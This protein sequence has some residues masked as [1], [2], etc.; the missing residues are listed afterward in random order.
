VKQI[1]KRLTYAN[2]MSSIAV[3]LMLGGATAFAATKIGSNEIKGNAITTGKIKK[4]AVSRAK[5]KKNAI[6]A[7]KLADGSVTNSKLAAD[8]VTGDKVKDGSLTGADLNL[9]TVGTVPSANNA[10]AV[11]GQSIA[12]FFKEVPTN[13]AAV[14]ALEFGGVKLTASCPA[15]VP[16]LTAT[17]TSGIP[18]A[19]R[20]GTV[21]EAAEAFGNGQTSF[22]TITVTNAKALGAGTV[23]AVFN[24]GK[25]TSISLAYR[26]D[27]FNGSGC[28]FFGHAITG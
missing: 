4:E 23:E 21:L 15:T 14:T 26:S 11:N 27:A 5:I 17:N 22:S 28:R 16:N 19:I 25:V 9:G 8:A 3:F 6:D 13:G 7:S 12:S 1:R 20:F 24:N 2:V 18:G 10:N